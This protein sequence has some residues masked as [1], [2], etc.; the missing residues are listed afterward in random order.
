MNRD[1]WGSMQNFM[2]DF[3]A[4]A[5]NPAQFVTQ[6]M[7]IS[8]DI[9]DDPDAIIQKLM[10]DGK[11]SQQQYNAARQAAAKIQSNPMFKQLMK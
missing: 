4:M 9:A 6:K 5:Q 10:S 8:Q 1:P 3:R 7:G 11:L 2:N